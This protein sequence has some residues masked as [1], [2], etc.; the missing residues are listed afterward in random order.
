MP[1]LVNDPAHWAER[2]RQMRGLAAQTDDGGAKQA[3]LRVAFD[4]DKL[5][6][7]ATVRSDGR[8]SAPVR[9]RRVANSN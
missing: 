4:Y 9:T 5:A 1:N 3:M 2:A 6:E 8:W 7:R